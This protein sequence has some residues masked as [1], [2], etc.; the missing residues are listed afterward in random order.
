[1]CLLHPAVNSL[2]LPI[3]LQAT[4]SK[5]HK[6]DLLLHLHINA[7]ALGHFPTFV[8]FPIPVLVPT[9]EIQ[10][11]HLAPSPSN[12]DLSADSISCDHSFPCEPL[13]GVADESAPNAVLA[14]MAR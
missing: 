14:M 10:T 5:I 4:R 13:L 12:W 3:T 1:M 7:A 11:P 2:V 9:Q 6:R 8:A